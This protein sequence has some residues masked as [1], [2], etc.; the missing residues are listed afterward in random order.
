MEQS[1]ARRAL[2]AADHEAEYHQHDESR[3]TTDGNP[4]ANRSAIG[5]PAEARTLT[6]PEREA[7]RHGQRS[8]Q[9]ELPRSGT[10]TQHLPA[11]AD[12]VDRPHADIEPVGD[13]TKAGK[14]PQHK[15]GGE[16]NQ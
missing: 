5:P 6:V 16:A 13:E 9:P 8:K 3:Q 4:H 1:P 11:I 2:F 7:E 15:S 10:A 12:A 14:E